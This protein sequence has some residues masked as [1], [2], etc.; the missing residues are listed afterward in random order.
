MGDLKYV[1]IALCVF[2]ILFSAWSS[3]TIVKYIKRNRTRSQNF[4]DEK[5]F[6]LKSK[7]EYLAYSATLVIA[8]IS[9]IGYGSIKD[10]RDDFKNQF[11]TEKISMD[12]LYKAAKAKLDSLNSSAGE[13]RT[14]F[15][16]LQGQ[17][18]GLSESFALLQKHVSDLSKKDILMQNLYIVDNLK[19]NNFPLAFPN[20]DHSDNNR[21]V[22]FD[23]LTTVT[24]QKLPK[25]RETP[26]FMVFTV[27]GGLANVQKTT[28]NGF[29]ISTGLGGFIM[30]ENKNYEPTNNLSFSIWIFQKQ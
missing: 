19:M 25:F 29:E 23:K 2:A 6:E 17:G 11:V 13:T 20:A 18:K 28:K 26:S 1:L 8:I 12:S 14:T 4:P 21:Y 24:G 9:F 5:Y 27:N 16:S 15:T 30:T 10:A 3:I 22:S 7:Q